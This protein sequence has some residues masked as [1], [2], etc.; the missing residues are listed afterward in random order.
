MKIKLALWQYAIIIITVV[1]VSIVAY[2]FYEATLL[3]CPH[4]FYQTPKGNVCAQ[5]SN[6]PTSKQALVKALRLKAQLTIPNEWYIISRSGHI[7]IRCDGIIHIQ[8]RAN[9]L[10]YFPNAVICYTRIRNL[11]HLTTTYKSIPRCPTCKNYL[12]IFNDKM[13]NTLRCPKCNKFYRK[14]D[15]D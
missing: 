9:I 15:F 12:K 1:I 3:Y 8:D 10:F 6:H 5:L 4:G 2:K 7:D 14:S 11:V 13:P